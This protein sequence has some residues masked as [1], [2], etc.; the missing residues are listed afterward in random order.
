M[1]TGLPYL[2]ET[3]P[4]LKN[5]MLCVVLCAKAVNLDN[6]GP[7]TI[8]SLYATANM[9]CRYKGSNARYWM[10]K[11]EHY[12]CAAGVWTALLTVTLGTP[13]AEQYVIRATPA[14][15]K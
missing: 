13:G 11:H 6:G 9:K 8:V 5:T 14:V 7:P 1:P 4:V 2:G 3:W 15:R 12:C 10:R